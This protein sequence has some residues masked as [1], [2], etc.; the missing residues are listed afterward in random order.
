MKPKRLIIVGGVA[1]GATA[2]TRARRLDESAEIILIERGDNISFANCGLPYYVGGSIRDRDDLLVTTAGALRRR[3]RIDVRPASE[4]LSIDRFSR[5]IVVKKLIDENTYRLDYD[6]LILSPGAEP[7][8]PPIKGVDS[9]RIFTL[10]NL[11][12]TDRI[13]RV[14][15]NEQPKR[16]L[17]VG[18]GFIGLEMV[19]NLVGLGLEVTIVELADQVMGTVDYEMAAIVHAHLR[20]KGVHLALESKVTEFRQSANQ[21]TV[22]TDRGTRLTGDFVILA[23][24]VRAENKLARECGLAIGPHGGIITDASMRTSDSHIYAVGDAVEVK[25]LVGGHS[26]MTL[27]AGPAHKQGRIAADNAM[28]RKSV[29]KGALGTSIVKIFDLSVASTGLNEK[30]LRQLTIPY[31]KSFTDGESHA[32]YYPGAEFMMIKLLF[33]PADG[34]L[35]GAQAV[36]GKGVDKRID[37]LATAIRA[38]LTVYDLEDLELA[39]APP[40]SSAKDPV[41][42]AGFHAVNILKGDVN[43][44]HWHQLDDLDPDIT[45]IIDVRGAEEIEKEGEIKGAAKIPLDD[46]RDSVDVLDHRKTYVVFCLA[47]LRSYV[48]CR[49]LSAHGYNCFSLS[50]GYGLYKNVV[51]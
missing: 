3:Y 39:Y 5:H 24:G 12:D 44:I 49:I 36:G 40:F 27:T 30:T 41:N 42:I 9:D 6:V 46:L 16:A 26:F 25:S 21:I 33:S 11:P 2:A 10:R 38:D 47:G 37:V 7:I 23:I 17:V 50:G 18:G 14:I 48:G 31:L 15:D 34:R 13:K 35:L 51:E 4:V 45:A 22:F 1:G 32:S 19:E 8:R 43:C 20:E 29:Y 28:G